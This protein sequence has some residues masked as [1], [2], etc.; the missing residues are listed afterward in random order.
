MIKPTQMMVACG[1]MW[2]LVVNLLH[3]SVI[4]HRNVRNR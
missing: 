2:S 1:G 3:F 4:P